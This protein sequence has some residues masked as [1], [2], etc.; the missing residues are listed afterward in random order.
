MI[1]D[2]HQGCFSRL[3]DTLLVGPRP[4]TKQHKCR[5][6]EENM[7]EHVCSLDA[8]RPCGNE[9]MFPLNKVPNCTSD[10]LR[11][12]RMDLGLLDA[13]KTPGSTLK[14]LNDNL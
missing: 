11:K 1:L 5:I 12:F 7:L 8:S 4:K 9:G 10:G 2:T 3:L 13:T 6:S 14:Y